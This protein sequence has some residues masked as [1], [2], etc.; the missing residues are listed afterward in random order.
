M[1]ATQP[2]RKAEAHI[3]EGLAVTGLFQSLFLM[4]K[5]ASLFCSPALSV[6]AHDMLEHTSEHGRAFHVNAL[7]GP[8]ATVLPRRPGPWLGTSGG[9]AAGPAGPETGGVR[10]AGFSFVHVP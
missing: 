6:R 9:T 1:N 3:L 10:Q 5:S 7:G 2:S 4:L 8:T